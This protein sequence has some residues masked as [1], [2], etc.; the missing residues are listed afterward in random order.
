MTS[1]WVGLLQARWIPVSECIALRLP[2]PGAVVTWFVTGSHDIPLEIEA[3]RT[4]RIRVD[5]GIYGTGADRRVIAT[6]ATASL[7]LMGGC[8]PGRSCVIAT[9]AIKQRDRPKAGKL[10]QA[11]AFDGPAHIAGVP[12]PAQGAETVHTR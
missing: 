1:R 10:P 6:A 8:A 9:R 4:M 11:D 7:Q 2:L 3:L 5:D 12:S